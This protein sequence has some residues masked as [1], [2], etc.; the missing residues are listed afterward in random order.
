MYRCFKN[1]KEEKWKEAKINK[2]IRNKIDSNEAKSKEK[3][4]N[5]IQGM[6]ILKALIKNKVIK[7]NKNKEKGKQN[8]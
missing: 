4:D 5:N 7:I 1:T 2:E 3:L 6:P 8:P